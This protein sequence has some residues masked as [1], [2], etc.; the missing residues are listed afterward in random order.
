[1][2]DAIQ[3][4]LTE[5]NPESLEDIF[6]CS[7]LDRKPEE[8]TKVVAELRRMREIWIKEEATG[9]TK[10]RA[11]KSAKAAKPKGVNLDLTDFD[12]I[13]FTD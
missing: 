10:S 9:A 12:N 6:S 8:W 4:P 5:T 3:T 2:S 11:A 7:P 1:M 13:S